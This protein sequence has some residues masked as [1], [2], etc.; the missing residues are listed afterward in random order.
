MWRWRL[1]EWELVAV[2]TV[3]ALLFPITRHHPLVLIAL[4]AVSPLFWWGLKKLK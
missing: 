4:V 2:A 1:I 3:T